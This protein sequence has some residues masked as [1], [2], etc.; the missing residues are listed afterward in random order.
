MF[1]KLGLPRTA[2]AVALLAGVLQP[3]GVARAAE[4]VFGDRT[5]IEA[6]KRIQPTVAHVRVK[7]P[8]IRTGSFMRLFGPMRRK[9]AP[10][11]FG[12]PDSAAS[13]G[14]GVII[15]KDGYILTNYHVIKEAEGIQ[16]KLATGEELPARVAGSDEKYD[17]AL[18][19]IETKKKLTPAK[20]GD[21]DTVEVGEWVIA[22]GSPFGLS[23]SISVGII[24]AKGR[25]LGQ[26][27]YDDFLQTDATINPG[28]SGG[29]LANSRGEVIGIST[30]IYTLGHTNNSQGVG[31]AVPI[32]QAKSV[33]DSLRHKGYPIRG[34]LG[35]SV[36]KVGSKERE[37][38]DLFRF[39]GARL[40]SVVRG[41]PAHRAG[42]R[43]GDVIVEFNGKQVVSWQTLPRI[44][45]RARPKSE[46][47]VNFYRGSRL[48]S[49]R[50]RIG[51]LPDRQRKRSSRIQKIL[52]MRVQALTPY[53]AKRF[54][55]ENTTGLVI[56]SVKPGE[57]AERGGIRAGDELLEINN[58][59]VSGLPEFKKII[60]QE[61]SEGSALFLLRRK[62]SK[63][64]AAIRFKT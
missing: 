37:K 34:R 19:K 42:L 57:P 28:N 47:V 36:G 12:P 9:D 60:R 30:A 45:A 39:Q 27:P 16:V 1:Y 24:S 33:I 49:V 31:F 50:V 4:P 53:I 54:H 41:G 20:L 56:V 15:S 11:D 14:A 32:N 35:V 25:D 29:P 17:L 23:H 51:T 64:F 22:M 46:A 13:V 58:I 5:F 2:L 26:S 8:R 61:R 59:K 63:F 55:L 40:S 43:R 38:L 10:F 62:N 18:L 6:A 48:K 21:S 52:G 7:R 44:V 3:I